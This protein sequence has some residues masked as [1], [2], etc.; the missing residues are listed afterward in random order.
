MMWKVTFL[1][2]CKGTPEI[3]IIMQNNVIAIKNCLKIQFL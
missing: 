2:V 3:Y 1:E